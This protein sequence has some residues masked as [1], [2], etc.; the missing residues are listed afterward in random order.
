MALCKFRHE[1]AAPTDLFAKNGGEIFD[2]GNRCRKAEIQRDSGPSRKGAESK[3]LGEEV[4]ERLV[5]ELCET[6]R[7]C[8][9][10]YRC[11]ISKRNEI[12]NDFVSCVSPF[13]SNR[14]YISAEILAGD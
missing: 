11:G 6:G 5:V 14:V 12:A 2:H 8:E 4:N 1:E 13:P 10:V 9:D 7:P 3:L